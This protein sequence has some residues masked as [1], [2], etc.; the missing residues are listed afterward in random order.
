MFVESSSSTNN[1]GQSSSHHSN[2]GP[3]ALNPNKGYQN[4]TLNPYFMH[5]NE[6]SAFVHITSLLNAGNYHSWSWSMTMA[7]RS[8]N[9]LNF[10]NGSLPRPLDE[11]CYS[12]AYDRCNTMIMSW[13]NNSVKPEYS[14]RISWMESA[15]SI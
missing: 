6:N 10:I 12:I 4:Y 8:K 15:F 5:P 7:L 14:Q 11:D 2:D 13:L 3:S 9:K 1:G